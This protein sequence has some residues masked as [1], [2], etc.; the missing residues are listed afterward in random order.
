ML[1][2]NQ[3]SRHSTPQ[4][5]LLSYWC[6]LCDGLNKITFITHLI[7]CCLQVCG[8]MMVNSRALC[9]WFFLVLFLVLLVLRL[10][11]KVLWSWFIVFIPMWLM[12]VIMIVYISIFM[13][14]HCATG[15]DPSGRT[16]LRK[17]YCIVCVLFKIAV[18]VLVCVRAEH[19]S[20]MAATF[21]VV[22]VWLL[23]VAL[24][25]DVS[26]SVVRRVS[27]SCDELVTSCSC[28]NIICKTE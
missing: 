17:S 18:E 14:R 28:R 26:R 7:C 1:T 11:E 12:D 23:L 5:L 20:M 24:T 19:V 13:I 4:Y 8:S 25:V 21:A 15:N 22:P 2:I 16:M 3:P 9:T 27:P 6:M 10:D